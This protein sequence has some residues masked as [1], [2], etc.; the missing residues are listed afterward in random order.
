M[1]V[2]FFDEFG[3]WEG[4]MDLP[5]LQKYILSDTMEAETEGG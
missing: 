4:G 5:L 1:S 3:G 2:L